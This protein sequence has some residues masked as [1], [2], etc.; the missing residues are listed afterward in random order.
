MKATAV[1]RLQFTSEKP[2]TAVIRALEPELGR[3]NS[4]RSNVFLTCDS[5]FL[6][7]RIEAADSVA[8][9][10]AINA[11]LRWISSAMNVFEAVEKASL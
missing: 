6:V 10:A 2:L 3:A 7:L 11:Y 8:L 1:V 4:A 9:R 5:G